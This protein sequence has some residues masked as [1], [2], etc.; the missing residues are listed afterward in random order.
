M[1]HAVLKLYPGVNVQQ[2]PALNENSG[3]SSSQLVRWFPDPVLGALIQKTGGWSRF[4]SQPF[5]AI[6]RA[7]WAWEDLND[8]SHLAAGTQTITGTPSAE[9]A[10]ITN[11]MLQNITPTAITDDVTP[12]VSATMGNPI[13]QITDNT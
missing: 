12:L 6:V 8:T 4:F 11:G 3:V 5:P 2:T 1:P 10:V 9:L 7:L 13:V